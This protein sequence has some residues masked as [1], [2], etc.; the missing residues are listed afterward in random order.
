MKTRFIRIRG[1]IVPIKQKS[2]AKSLKVAV[3]AASALTATGIAVNRE[4]EK[5][6]KKKKGEL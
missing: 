4:L 3:V 5:R 2:L 6:E 1:R